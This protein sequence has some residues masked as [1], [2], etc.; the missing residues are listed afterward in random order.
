MILRAKGI[1]DNVAYQRHSSGRVAGIYRHC[2][3]ILDEDGELITVFG[4]A[5]HYSTR[6]VLCECSKAMWELP[7]GE[8]MKVGLKPG[9][10]QLPHMTIDWSEAKFIHLHRS[11]LFINDEQRK[12]AEENITQ[13]MKRVLEYIKSSGKISPL[14]DGDSVIAK[15][16]ATGIKMLKTDYMNGLKSLI[17]L[18]IGLTPSC[19]DMLGGMAAWMY[20]TGKEPE[21]L[22]A[23]CSFLNVYGAVYTT[24]VSRNL[25]RDITS[26]IINDEIYNLICAIAGDGRDLEFL[27]RCVMDYGSTS[28][29]ET[30]LGIVMGYQFRKDGE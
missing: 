11:P 30:G 14:L 16:A 7:I 10:I 2:F 28:G 6:A 1:C 23:L 3:N 13:N 20:L 27:T 15:K 9:K 8:G 18:G 19:D 25:L 29:I 26:G 17:G 4:D 12:A 5:E 22:S 21:F 24:A